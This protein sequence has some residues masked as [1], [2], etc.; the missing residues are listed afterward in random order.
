MSASAKMPHVWIPKILTRWDEISRH[1]HPGRKKTISPGSHLYDLIALKKVII[2]CWECNH[3][4]YPHHKSQ[5]YRVDPM[6]AN[7]TCD[8]CH[9]AS[10]TANIYIHEEGWTTVH[11]D[12]P[13]DKPGGF[14][15]KYEAIPF[16]SLHEE[17]KAFLRE[18]I[19]LK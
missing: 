11:A 3:K 19:Q 12:H 8:L 13:G 18:T 7:A 5:S 14:V 15:Q 4:F 10:R 9:R 1:F 6:K 17:D 16:K 2:L